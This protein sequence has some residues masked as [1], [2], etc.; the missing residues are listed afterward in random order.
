MPSGAQDLVRHKPVIP[1]SEFVEISVGV[2]DSNLSGLVLAKGAIHFQARRT[3]VVP[4][5][6]G[7]GDV[8]ISWTI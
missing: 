7:S 4:I 1:L 8:N 3:L 6:A 5:H 2:K